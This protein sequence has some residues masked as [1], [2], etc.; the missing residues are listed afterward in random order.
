MYGKTVLLL[1]ISVCF[2]GVSIP[3]VTAQFPTNG[4]VGYW[5]FDVGTIVGQTV[6]DILGEN[7]GEFDGNPKTV[8][9]RVGNALEFNGDDAV[10]IQ[11]TDSLNFNGAE[12]MSVAAWIN[13]AS[14]KPVK[15]VIEGT[16]CGTIV[17]QRD[18]DG[19]VLRF[20]G[21]NANK[22]MVLIA[23]PGWQGHNTL[24]VPPFAKNTW[25]H[26]VG[27]VD[28]NKLLLYVDG[29][30]ADEFD[31]NGPMQSKSTVTEIGNAKADGGFVGIIDEVVIYNR[32]VNANEVRQL[33]L[34][35]G[36]AVKAQDRLT[37]YW[38]RIKIGFD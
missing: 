8:V 33:Y 6:Q 13:P 34:A 38:G 28:K 16:C 21:R 23:Q 4:V 37:T 18:A 1:T 22:E 31:Y 9:G 2:L 3:F 10:R 11:G 26:L 15:G 14:D 20:D 27:V 30:L 12:E 25:H 24:G 36:L 7:S 29:K 35:E 19:W 5:S 17:G 32:A